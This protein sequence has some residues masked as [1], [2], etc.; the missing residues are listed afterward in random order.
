MTAEDAQMGD[1]FISLTFR[2]S[3]SDDDDDEEDERS[4]GEEGEANGPD[5]YADESED[6]AYLDDEAV[7]T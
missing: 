3:D 7:T 4:D 2:E 6:Y 1:E 5:P